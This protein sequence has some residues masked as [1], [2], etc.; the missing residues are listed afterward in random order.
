MSPK[1]KKI[2]DPSKPLHVDPSTIDITVSVTGKIPRRNFENFSPYF[3]IKEIYKDYITDDYRAARQMDLSK[4]IQVY[5]NEIREAVKLEELQETFKNL[6]FTLNPATGRKYPHVT[7]ILYWDAEFYIN[8]DELTQYGAR[9]SGIHA[10]IEGWIQTGSSGGLNSNIWDK[11]YINKRDVILL[12]SGSLR[13]WDTLDSINFVGFMEKYGKDI[14]FGDGEFRGFNEEHFYCGQP[15]RIGSYQDV[16]AIFDF[17][18]RE[19]KDADFKQ[20]AMYLKLDDPRLKGISRMVIIP[21]NSDNKSGYGKPVVS[22]E[23]EK[24]FNLALRDRHD[25]RDKF[26][27]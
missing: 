5:F 15:D 8:P 22:D 26:G 20:M 17:K 1:T 27:I 11:S 18:C 9:G 2:T 23:A 6:R 3:S 25:Y 4:K 12:K 19:A 21:L 7:D 10:M 14:K 16:P 24:Y 13:L